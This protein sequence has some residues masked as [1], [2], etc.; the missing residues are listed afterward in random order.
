MY[1]IWNLAITPTHLIY[2]PDHLPHPP[3]FSWKG[4][5]CRL[6][7]LMKARVIFWTSSTSHLIVSSTTPFT[8]V[9]W[10]PN[11]AL[12][13]LFW[14]SHS[15][16][17]ENLGQLRSS[18]D[19]PI[20]LGIIMQANIHFCNHP[21]FLSVLASPFSHWIAL[22]EMLGQLISP[23]L[24]YGPVILNMTYLVFDSFSFNLWLKSAVM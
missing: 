8:S 21:W 15:T 11:W 12:L 4:C 18:W 14:T 22:S 24:G 1:W 10:P 5:A 16:L 6:Y 13:S 2:Y 20:P 17:K 23:T 9:Q 7:S 3:P 19:E